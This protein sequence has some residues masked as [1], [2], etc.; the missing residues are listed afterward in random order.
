MNNYTNLYKSD[1]NKEINNNREY[2]FLKNIGNNND[3]DEFFSK[4]D[5][6]HKYK[7]LI[8][9]NNKKYN[10]YLIGKT[11]DYLVT[12]NEEKIPLNEIETIEIIK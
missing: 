10:T 4:L 2:C 9:T 11:N 3:I 7:Y 6:I 12:F 8:K 5:K 1:I